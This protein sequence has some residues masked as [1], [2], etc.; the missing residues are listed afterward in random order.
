MHQFAF[1]VGSLFK[2]SGGLLT[3]L[4][5]SVACILV[6]VIL[7]KLRFGIAPSRDPDR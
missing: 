2:G 7:G 6:V 4:H 1:M 5:I 3:R